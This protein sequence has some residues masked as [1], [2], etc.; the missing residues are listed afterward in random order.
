MAAALAPDGDVVDAFGK[1]A[2]GRAEAEKMWRDELATSLRGSV[3]VVAVRSVR[4]ITADVA[5]ADFDLGLTHVASPE[6]GF[7]PT[8]HQTGAAVLVHVGGAWQ[9]AALRIGETRAPL[10]EVPAAAK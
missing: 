6:G 7:L 9:I 2:H 1:S 10:P 4:S 8:L 3:P 5:I